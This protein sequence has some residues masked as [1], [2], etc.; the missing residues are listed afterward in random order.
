MSFGRLSLSLAGVIG[1]LGA[2]LAGAAVWLLITRPVQTATAVSDLV[3]KGE[4]SPLLRAV[5]AV[6]YEALQGILKYL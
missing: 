2:T 4:A 5:G 3:T 1:A 6:I